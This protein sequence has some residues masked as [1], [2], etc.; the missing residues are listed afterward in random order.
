M[1]S[2]MGANVHPVQRCITGHHRITVSEAL[3]SE[4]TIYVGGSVNSSDS[5]V[6]KIR[7]NTFY[8]L[9]LALM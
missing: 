6:M 5:Y 3:H 9:D 7:L 2:H 1:E 8:F 4:D